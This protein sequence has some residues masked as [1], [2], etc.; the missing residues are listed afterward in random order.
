M[1]RPD[2]IKRQ[3]DITT[4]EKV[5]R[6]LAIPEELEERDIAM[7]LVDKRIVKKEENNEV[8]VDEYFKRILDELTI[9]PEE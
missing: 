2:E 8:V 3:K 6:I 9:K 1:I 7:A 5:A 4:M